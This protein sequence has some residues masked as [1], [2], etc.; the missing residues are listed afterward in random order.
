MNGL[1][2]HD[3][4]LKGSQQFLFQF[5]EQ[6]LML[7]KYAFRWVHKAF[8]RHAY[9]IKAKYKLVRP[10]FIHSEWILDITIL[11]CYDT[12]IQRGINL[13]YRF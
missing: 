11:N 3:S 9:V 4:E 5:Y 12:I 7:S 1:F 2:Q 13:S 6:M 8:Y 10:T